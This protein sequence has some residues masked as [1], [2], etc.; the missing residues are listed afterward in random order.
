VTR[1]AKPRCRWKESDPPAGGGRRCARSMNLLSAFL[2]RGILNGNLMCLQG[3][4]C[5]AL[6]SNAAVMNS[7]SVRRST[8]TGLNHPPSI[9]HGARLENELTFFTGLLV[10]TWDVGRGD[11]VDRSDEE[12][13]WTWSTLLRSLGTLP[14]RR[15]PLIQDGVNGP[16]SH[17]ADTIDFLEAGSGDRDTVS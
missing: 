16:G 14:G 15:F 10:S 12:T 2:S 11:A 1:T 3:S 13:W 8:A 6:S 7:R 4:F 9:T 17:G 5:P